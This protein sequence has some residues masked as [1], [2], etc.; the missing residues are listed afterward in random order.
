MRLVR[1]LQKIKSPKRSFVDQQS[2]PVNV[3]ASMP[4]TL[5]ACAFTPTHTFLS[6]ERLDDL[7]FAIP[8]IFA[9]EL[10]RFWSRRTMVGS[11]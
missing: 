5:G 3:G 10:Y 2:S 6:V 9:C 4:G 8:L 1:E 11:L 7:Y